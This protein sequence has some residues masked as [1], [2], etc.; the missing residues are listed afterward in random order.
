MALPKSWIEST[1]RTKEAQQVVTTQLKEP[2]F[3]PHPYPTNPSLPSPLIKVYK[4][5]K[6]EMDKC[7]LKGICY[8]CDEKYFMGHKCKEKNI[9][10]AISKDILEDEGVV[11]PL[12]SF[13]SV[14]D[15]SL[16]SDQ[17][18]VEPIIYM[19]SHYYCIPQ[20]LKLIGYIKH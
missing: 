9:F 6:V 18:E 19:H 17:P 8:N 11:F 3:I 10:M 12:E 4:L 13:P 20:T 1:N 2:S 16:P 15:L 7:Q 5:T 14:E